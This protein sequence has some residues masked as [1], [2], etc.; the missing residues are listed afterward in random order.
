MVEITAPSVATGGDS[1]TLGCIVTPVARI[2]QLLSPQ[3]YMELVKEGDVDSIATSPG[4]N[5]SHIVSPVL[6]S[7]G[8]IYHCRSV[9]VVEGLPEPLSQSINHSLT[10]ISKFV[11]PMNTL[12]WLQLYADVSSSCF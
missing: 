8:G 5:L 2:L 7:H 6:A 1:V 9:L 3:S 10:V 11:T 12:S 4:L